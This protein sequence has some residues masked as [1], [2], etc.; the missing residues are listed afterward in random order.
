[1]IPVGPKDVD[2]DLSVE[3]IQGAGH[4]GSHLGDTM[5]IQNCRNRWRP[6]TSFWGAQEDWEKAGAKEANVCANQRARQIL[7]DAPD[8]L[9]D[10]A[11]DQELRAYIEHECRYLRRI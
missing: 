4:T 5:T 7:N 3:S 11:L 10:G 9:I 8:R 1:M 2:Q 6:S